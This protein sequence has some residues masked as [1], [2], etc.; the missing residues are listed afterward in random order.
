MAII[1]LIGLVLALGICGYWYFWLARPMGEGPAGSAVDAVAFQH[2]WTDR[3]VLLLALG[4]SITAGFGVPHDHGYVARAA[5][6][7]RDEW[8]DMKDRCLRRVIP[9]LSVRN[10]AVSG[11]TSLEHI[12]LVR[13]A[14]KTAD[15]ETLGLV[16]ITTGGNDLIHW[17][18]TTPP[19][20]G[21][22]YGATLEQARPW[23]EAFERRLGEML[24]LITER[25][26]GGCHIFLADIYDPSDGVG[27]PASAYLKPWPDCLLILGAYNDAIRRTAAA[28]P[29]VHVVPIHDAFL[30]H[31]VHCTQFWREHYRWD[32]PHYW[33]GMNLE[34]PNDRG[35]DA[36]RRLFLIEMIK[37][38][39][40]KEPQ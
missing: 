2:V 5:D 39:E 36:V 1:L 25:F 17:Y 38:L 21:A 9:N 22:M 12:D 29:N 24:D 20:E 4:D 10:I 34:D 28:R 16:V 30:G 19:R 40:K 7:P 13:E 37:V 3:K 31:G 15:A 23:I 6:N 32:D 11:S 8:P 14:V 27:D 35:F 18:G 33:Y 26:P